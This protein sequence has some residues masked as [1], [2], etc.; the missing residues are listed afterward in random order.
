VRCAAVQGALRLWEPGAV[1]LLAARLASET[2]RPRDDLRRAL[3]TLT[4]KAIGE[5]PELW[6][7]WWKANEATFDPGKRPAA[8]GHGRVPFRDAGETAHDAAGSKTVSFF[9]I[10]LRSQRLAFLFDLSGSMRN[11]ARKGQPKP[12]KLD[13]L[14][15]EFERAVGALPEETEFD[16]FVYR[17]PSDFPP[18]PKLTRAL[19]KL[20]PA[21]KASVRKAVKW[22]DDQEA[23]GWGAF[24]EPLEALLAD[25]VDTIVLLSDGRPSRGRYDRD[26]RILEEFPL[27]NRFRQVAVHTV[28]VGE[29]G[30]DRRFME[31][32]A[33]ATGGRSR[34]AGA[35]R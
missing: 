18:A 7:A 23:K 15:D 35:S 9:E 6:L 16:V 31:D 34:A 32:L 22:L 10:P 28:L 8:D 29:V 30:A 17:Y 2:G 1:P 13:L 24:Y 33:A 20:A 11:E 14:R 27:A 25:E 3:E 5:D 21:T 12:T 26:D 19:G 4:G